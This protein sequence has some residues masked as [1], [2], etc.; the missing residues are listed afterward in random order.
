LEMFFA[1]DI[2]HWVHSSKLQKNYLSEI[3]VN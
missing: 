3:S 2:F 1:F